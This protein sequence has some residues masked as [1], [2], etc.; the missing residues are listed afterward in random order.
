MS[1]LIIANWKMNFSF[2]QAIEFCNLLPQTSSTN[3][4]IIAPPVPYLA[5]LA[6]NFSDTDFCAQNVSSISSNGAY[7]GE[8]SASMLK[9]CGI[10][11]CLVG[12]SERRIL[13]D[14]ENAIIEKMNNLIAAIITP[15]FCVGEPAK[16]R[17]NNNYKSFIE[18]QLNTI[19]QVKE[20]LIIAY[21]PVWSI[22]S[23]K[24]LSKDDIND[25]IEFISSW[26]EQ[27][28]VANKVSIVYGG[29]V[30]LNNIEQI[31][32]ISKIRGVLLGNASLDYRNLVQILNKSY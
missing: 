21:E 11:Y 30:N 9:S 22:G 14:D 7:T 16:A 10:N 28:A 19:K 20:D 1:R 8:Y 25:M 12:H 32:S 26:A 2:T 17:I 24:I 4:L 3:Q 13:F 18:A 23:N 6:N 31:L 29:S 15:I 5:Y 27:K